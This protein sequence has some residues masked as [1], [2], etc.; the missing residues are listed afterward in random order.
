MCACGIAASAH[1]LA[2]SLRRSRRLDAGSL[3]L[4]AIAVATVVSAALW[5]GNDYMREALA[6]RA[7]A[8]TEVLANAAHGSVCVGLLRVL[9]C[10]GPLD[11]PKHFCRM[12]TTEVA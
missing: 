3:V 11:A 6:A 2:T 12:A 4:W 1:S 9:L 10:H 8:G 7:G 5:A